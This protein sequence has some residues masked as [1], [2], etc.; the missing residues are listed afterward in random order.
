MKKNISINIGGIIFHIEEDSYD[1]LNSYL[2]SIN[3]YFETF[4]DSKEILDDIENRIAEIF[5]GKLNDGKQVI[6]D[7]DIDELIQTMGTVADF[8]AQIEVDES[9]RTVEPESFSTTSSESEDASQE[10]A[11]SN[12]GTQKRLYRDTNGRILGGVASGIAHYFSID[13]LWVRLIFLLIFFNI[14]FPAVTGAVFL[15]YIVL[16]IVV[17]GNDQLVE[18]KSYKKLYRNPDDRVLGG[19]S[20][21]IASFFGSDPTVI[22]LLF[23]LSIF[24][25]GAGLILYIILWIITP[26]AGSITE[27]MQMQGEPVTLSNIESNVKN[28]LK[29]KEGEESVFVKILLF[30]FRLI[31][32]IF[33]SLGKV[34]GPFLKF[35][36]DAFR[37][38]VG[39]LIIF[40]GASFMFSALIVWGVLIGIA[41]GWSEWVHL[42]DFPVELFIGNFNF[43]GVTALFGVLFIPAL[44]ISILGIIVIVRRKIGNSYFGWTLF[45]IWMVC[46]VIASFMIPDF[47]NDYRTDED[48][49]KEEVLQVSDT[50]EI[51]TLR[52]NRT[53]AFKDYDGVDLRLRGHSDSTYK[54][55]TRFE[56]RG[57][58]SREA[59]ENAEALAYPI[60][61]RNGDIFFDEELD[62]SDVGFKFQRADVIFYIPFGQKFRMESDLAEILV[63][64]LHLNNYRAYQME[65]NDWMFDK[66]GIVCLTCENYDEDGTRYRERSEKR[67]ISEERSYNID[68]KSINYDFTDF[69]SIRASSLML[70]NIEQGEEYKVEVKGRNAD[71]V[72]ISQ[73]G[74]ELVVRYRDD[75]DI[76]DNDGRRSIEISLNIQ[77]PD[78]D[79]IELNGGCDGKL[80]GF[81]NREL[82]ISLNGASDLTATIDT[83]RLDIHLTGA[84]KLTLEGEARNMDARLNGASM[85][86]A[87]NMTTQFAEI[88]SNGASKAEIYATELL[89]AEASG[90]SQ[91]RYRGD[92]QVN[93]NSDGIS[94]I[95][96]D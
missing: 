69:R 34:L 91:I 19:V 61:F 9:D 67:E 5:L 73:V 89:E 2:S 65:G 60:D 87:Y 85:L 93:S 15:A 39:L 71:E 27:K 38:L 76:W 59:R 25:G 64:T 45:G 26:E 12:Q 13:P 11:S 70:V 20:G 52:L 24:L 74:K 1:R 83:E 42:S 78:I 31:A 47:I 84:S 53:Y 92:A 58:N 63:N 41:E 55:V 48:V 57:S 37:I 40:I 18:D 21:G 46:L 51:P 44:A 66:S 30:P 43:I 94:T 77:A 8:E 32:L 82:E 35:L 4:D 3:R 14:L 86:E 96:R 16:W 50:T 36:V 10:G 80:I 22:R 75:W 33:G 29:V 62:F 68:S 88:N 6:V 28:S 23:V 95:R 72:R 79:E 90:V 54:V 17:P 56:S 49:R 81:N 7:E